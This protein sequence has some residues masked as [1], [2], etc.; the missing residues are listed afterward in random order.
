MQFAGKKK[1]RAVFVEVNK[2]GEL[3]MSEPEMAKDDG[4][5]T[6]LRRGTVLVSTKTQ[7]A[8]PAEATRVDH[9]R[10]KLSV[11]IA[12]GCKVGELKNARKGHDHAF[13]ID[14]A[15]KDR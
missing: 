1:W 9:Q 4:S 14:L 8:V 12:Q 13:R 11:V 5:R 10:S 7:R 3:L 2:Q 6:L 15:E